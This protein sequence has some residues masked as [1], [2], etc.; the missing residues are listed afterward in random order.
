MVNC[1]K[2]SKGEVG[3]FMKFLKL[4]LVYRRFYNN[5]P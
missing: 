3:V 4:V 2:I 5:K 1:A